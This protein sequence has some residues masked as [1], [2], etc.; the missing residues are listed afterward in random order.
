MSNTSSN[1]ESDL[2]HS[3]VVQSL[4]ATQASSEDPPQRQVMLSI[5]QEQALEWLMGG[6]SVSEA[7]NFAGVTRQTISRW[8]RTDA[9]FQEVYQVWRDETRSIIQS[10]MIAAGEVA[11]DAVVH[12]I[13]STGNLQASQFVLK[14]L[15]GQRR[16]TP[17]PRVEEL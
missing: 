10:R 12:A 1:R 5:Q 2:T 7:A 4:P 13:R 17:M 14:T 15:L 11:M 16:T 8:L 6:G 9:D 3:P